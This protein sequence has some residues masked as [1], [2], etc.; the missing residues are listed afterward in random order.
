MVMFLQKTSEIASWALMEGL[1][2]VLQ[3]AVTDS[4]YSF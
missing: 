2:G 1:S 3:E 4:F